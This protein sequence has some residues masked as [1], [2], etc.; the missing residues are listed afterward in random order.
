MSDLDDGST[1]AVLEFFSE[2][3]VGDLEVLLDVDGVGLSCFELVLV[4]QD[5]RS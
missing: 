3:S 1:V 2:S 4:G 5:E